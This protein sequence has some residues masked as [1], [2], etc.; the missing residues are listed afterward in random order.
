MSLSGNLQDVSI[1]DIM[2]FIHLG[3]RTGTLAVV[4]QEGTGTITFHRGWVVHA[5]SPSA[6]RLT[7]FLIARGM[8]RPEDA[9]RAAAAQQGSSPWRPIG[10]HLL[11]LG[12]ITQEKLHAAIR[13]HIE[14]SIYEL[15]VWTRGQFDFA[16]DDL[17]PL[18]AAGLD[19]SEI[20]PSIRLNTQMVLLEAMRLF[21][22]RNRTGAG[23]VVERH[24]R[25]RSAATVVVPSPAGAVP[26]GSEASGS[27]PTEIHTHPEL[28]H[29]EGGLPM[30]PLGERGSD[31]L[32]QLQKLRRVVV[33]MR[34]GLVSAT[35][36]LSLMNV[37]SESVERAILFAVRPKRLVALGAFGTTASGQPLAQV[38]AALSLSLESEN[39]LTHALRRARITT[40]AFDQSGL[41]AAMR[42]LIGA[43]RHPQVVA[44]P[45]VGQER[46]IL[47]IYADNG[48]IETGIDEVDV[49]GLAASQAGLAFENELL[50]RE[51]E[52]ARRSRSA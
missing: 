27:G 17:R 15:A 49:I 22:E 29:L 52:E 51:L 31:S 6:V 41:D 36:A 10:H 16:L 46:A 24:L 35:V 26:P 18:D 14:Q 32:F 21:D 13:T 30:Q 42:G 8:I 44:F 23:P 2:Q 33:E 28:E 4:G 12:L 5:Q 43:P 9:E 47:I 50:R 19:P 48:F 20:I 11:E 40:A 45:V 34:S 7:A 39:V 38:T 3:E 25:G 37:I 1:A